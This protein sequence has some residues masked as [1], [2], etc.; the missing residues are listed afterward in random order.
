VLLSMPLAHQ[1][2]E[3]RLLGDVLANPD[4]SWQQAEPEELRANYW[5]YLVE[6]GLSSVA[7]CDRN[8]ETACEEVAAKGLGQEVELK[9]LLG[10]LFEQTIQVFSKIHSQALEFVYKTGH[11]IEHLDELAAALRELERKREKYM[12]RLS[13]LDAGLVEQARA[14]HAAGDYPSS[15]AA[16]ADLLAARHAAHLTPSYAELRRWAE[17]SPPPPSW[18][19]E[20][21]LTG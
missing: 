5:E 1:R 16:L 4:N 18:Y 8:W 10:D 7:L 9:E 14:E 11:G 19:E 17:S 13:L 3:V 20:N 6:K 15:G 21:D 12:F 2:E